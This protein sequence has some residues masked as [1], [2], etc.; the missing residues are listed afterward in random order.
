MPVHKE[1][2]WSSHE[3]P[4]GPLTTHGLQSASWEWKNKEILSWL[5]ESMNR[6]KILTADT[7]MQS[8][9]FTL[10]LKIAHSQVFL[11]HDLIVSSIINYDQF[12]RAENGLQRKPLAGGLLWTLPDA[13]ETHP[14]KGGITGVI[15]QPALHMFPREV[16]SAHSRKLSKTQQSK[17]VINPV[18]TFKRIELLIWYLVALLKKTWRNT[19]VS[20][21]ASTKKQKSNK[22]E[23]E[24]VQEGGG[25]RPLFP[26]ERGG[27]LTQKGSESSQTEGEVGS[28][29]QGCL[30]SAALLRAGIWRQKLLGRAGQ[31]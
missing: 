12:S 23:A 22:E 2:D 29:E 13:A 26:A 30:T 28:P 31:D 25:T 1:H 8:C 7:W 19:K 9:T 4:G 5:R 6:P 18:R 11:R 10:P 3:E 24:V 20:F 27:G 17:G 14:C 16:L 21:Q 15:L